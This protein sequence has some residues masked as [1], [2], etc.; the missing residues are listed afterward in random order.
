MIHYNQWVYKWLSELNWSHTFEDQASLCFYFLFECLIIILYQIQ[1]G[2]KCV[3]PTFANILVLEPQLSL[4]LLVG[5]PDGT[6]LLE[7]IHCLL[8]IMVPK[9]PEDGDKV[10]PLRRPVQRM[11]GWAEGWE[12]G[13]MS[14]ISIKEK[15]LECFS[16][17]ELFHL[18]NRC[19]TESCSS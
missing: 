10:T 2:N 15:Y 19:A 7:A 14:C 16:I 5:V 11:D 17:Q 9:L 3:G 1:T 6:G 18:S 13:K 12:E 8:H 4:D